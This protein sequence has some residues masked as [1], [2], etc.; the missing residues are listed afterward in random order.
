MKALLDVASAAN[1]S[2]GATML[3]TGD[4]EAANAIL[5][6]GRQRVIDMRVALGED[7]GVAA[8]WAD[9]LVS[10]SAEVEQA[11]QQVASA[12]DGIA[13]EKIV[14]VDAET[15]DALKDID[16]VNVVKIDDKTAYVYGDNKD[17]NA[18]IDEIVAKHM[19][20][21]ST[22]ITAN[23]KSFWD[24]WFA[25]QNAQMRDKVVNIVKNVTETFSSLGTPKSADGNLF[26]FANGGGL[27]T[28]I[29]AG[30]PPITRFAEP[31]TQ[32]E[33]FISGKPDQ[34]DRNRQIWAETGNRLDA[35]SGLE[36]RIAEIVVNQGMPSTLVVRDVNERLIGTMAVV[37]DRKIDQFVE[38]QASEHRR[39]W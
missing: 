8:A 16:G 25:I 24:S 11:M 9:G 22:A 32:W 35:F 13:P 39:S 14:Q 28:G 7:P 6:E 12:V 21:K 23:D 19:P 5:D 3:M 38:Q 1:Q 27:D 31:E 26:T 15:A 18:K 37:A 33:A 30:G 10:S 34:R 36:S 17:A 2:A 20:G 29:Y 4:Q